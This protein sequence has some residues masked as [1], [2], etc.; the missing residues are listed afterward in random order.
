M[1]GNLVQARQEFRPVE[2]GTPQQ[3][4]VRPGSAGHPGPRTDVGGYTGPA[5]TQVPQGPPISYLRAPAA[6]SPSS[7]GPSAAPP[8]GLCGTSTRGAGGPRGA[9]TE[10][11]VRS[12]RRTSNPTPPPRPKTRA[13]PHSPTILG[14]SR[15]TWMRDRLRAQP[16]SRSPYFR[17]HSGKQRKG[18][19]PV[20]S[21]G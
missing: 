9:A 5:S 2:S 14:A 19:T 6:P 11:P 17:P 7:P 10:Q 3:A 4:V 8:P 15:P 20:G 16:E 18:F 13:Q 1:P 12:R 21:S